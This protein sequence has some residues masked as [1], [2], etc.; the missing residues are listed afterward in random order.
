MNNHRCSSIRENIF[1]FIHFQNNLHRPPEI[2]G[3]LHERSEGKKSWKKRFFMLRAS[4][5]YYS[6]KGESQNNKDLH[7]YADAFASRL[8]RAEEL[9]YSG[10]AWGGGGAAEKRAGGAHSGGR[11]S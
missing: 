10:R 9:L 4:G 6:T 11:A 3:Y 7:L 8:G 2:K 1:C 5:L